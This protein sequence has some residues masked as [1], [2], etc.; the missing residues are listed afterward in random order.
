[1]S[2]QDRQHYNELLGNPADLPKRLVTMHERVSKLHGRQGG[3]TLPPMLVLM[4][5]HL[6]VPDIETK[7]EKEKRKAQEA[8]ALVEEERRKARA[9]ELREAKKREKVEV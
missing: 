4:V 5:V 9:K 2:P 1:M 7:L 3:G 8:E 6:S